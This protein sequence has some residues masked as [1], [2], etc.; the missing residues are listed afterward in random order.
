MRVF[1]TP[2]SQSP[3]RDYGKQLEGK[4]TSGRPELAK[5]KTPRRFDT[6]L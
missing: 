5:I 2:F 6:P 4:D 1:S 3:N